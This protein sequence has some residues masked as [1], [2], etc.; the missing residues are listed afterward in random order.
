MREL[1]DIDIEDILC[2][3]LLDAVTDKVVQDYREGTFKYI[4]ARINTERRRRANMKKLARRMKWQ[5]N[6]AIREYIVRYRET[7][8]Q[9]QRYVQV[10]NQDWKP[11][12]VPASQAKSIS[13]I[14][15]KMALKKLHD[16]P[17][18]YNDVEFF[19]STDANLPAKIKKHYMAKKYNDISEPILTVGDVYKNKDFREFSA[20]FT[21][22]TFGSMAQ[23]ILELQNSPDPQLRIQ[24][25][26]F[27]IELGKISISQPKGATN[28]NIDTTGGMYA[29]LVEMSK[30]LP[31]NERPALPEDDLH[32]RELEDMSIRENGI[33]PIRAERIDNEISQLTEQETPRH[34]DNTNPKGCIDCSEFE[35]CNLQQ[36]LMLKDAIGW[37]R[38]SEMADNQQENETQLPDL[39]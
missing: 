30:P 23:C 6:T 1:I 27:W 33:D 18:D 28:I 12:T 31:V 22:Q 20:D 39:S 11:V 32:L 4:K 5:G 38:P 2:D 3:A 10:F 25:I 13:K 36:C 8:P 37:E 26:K 29:Q 7:H 17:I 9:K 34:C 14:Y 24:A 21:E 35:M 16:N 19:Q 15:R